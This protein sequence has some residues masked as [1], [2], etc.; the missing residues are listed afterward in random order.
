[1]LPCWGFFWSRFQFDRSEKCQIGP[2]LV[3]C[4]E[5]AETWGLYVVLVMVFKELRGLH[6]LVRRFLKSLKACNTS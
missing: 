4:I 6:H 1:M 5:I 2:F 3:K